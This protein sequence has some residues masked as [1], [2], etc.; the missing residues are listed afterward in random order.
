MLIPHYSIHASRVP[1]KSARSYQFR[2]YTTHVWLRSRVARAVSSSTWAPIGSVSCVCAWFQARHKTH[3]SSCIETLR[4]QGGRVASR[5]LRRP[6]AR[7]DMPAHR[8]AATPASRR[9]HPERARP[10][11]RAAVSCFCLS[12][13]PTLRPSNR[14]KRASVTRTSPPFRSDLASPAVNEQFDSRDET[15][16]IR[17]EK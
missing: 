16:V 6:P 13:R 3:Y 7:A 2:P 12:A 14:S 8:S 4:G 5:T 17:R 9:T 15:R 10:A 1:A 11:T